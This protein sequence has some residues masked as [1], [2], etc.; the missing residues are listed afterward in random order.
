M[1]DKK[2]LSTSTLILKGWLTVVIPVSVTILAIWFGLWEIFNL[3]YLIS[4]LLG[5]LI[6]WYYWAYSIEKWVRW[7]ADN[8][9]DQNRILNIGRLG[10]LLWKRETITN[11]LD[12]GQKENS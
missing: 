4:I 10:L 1:T 9:V 8:N 7:A 6:G 12:N 5:T 11:A 3:N 2:E